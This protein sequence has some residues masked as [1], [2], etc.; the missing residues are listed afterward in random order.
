[1][2][3]E[4]KKQM[5]RRIMWILKALEVKGVDSLEKVAT[6]LGKDVSVNDVCEC[7]KAASTVFSANSKYTERANEILKHHNYKTAAQKR[8]EHGKIKKY[9][10][11][12]EELIEITKKISS[13][14]DRM[15]LRDAEKIYGYSKSTIQGSITPERVGEELY[16]LYSSMAEYHKVTTNQDESKKRK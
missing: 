10:I 7:L 13:K 2:T 14:D 12:Q 9:K 8:V 6:F 4:E 11:P 15:T 3:E 16:S 5:Q 1:M